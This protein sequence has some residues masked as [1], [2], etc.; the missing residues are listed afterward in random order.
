MVAA[1]GAQARGEVERQA[2]LGEQVDDQ[3]AAH[4]V[5]VALY[6]W[7]R[8]IDLGV[9]DAEVGG[10]RN[11]LIM[12]GL[13]FDAAMLHGTDPAFKRRY[14]TIAYARSGLAELR[15][16]QDQYT[17][18]LDGMTQLVRRASSVLVAN[19]GRISPEISLVREAAPDDGRLHVAVIRARS[20]LDWIQVA[21][22]VLFQ[23]RWGDVRVEILSA[24]RVEIHSEAP[25]LV[26]HDGEVGEPVDRF[27]AEVAPASLT[28][29]VPRPQAGA[30]A[31]GPRR[32]PAR[33]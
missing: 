23:G 15:Y 2:V 20:R 21:S 10:S 12:A 11:F 8:A 26:E 18:T 4:A 17:I 27:A 13:G 9:A 33:A 3:G 7:R 24:R 22:R 19:L 32:P 25:H 30:T 1:E 29:C 28:V 16:P 6:G 5:E 14:G 31:A